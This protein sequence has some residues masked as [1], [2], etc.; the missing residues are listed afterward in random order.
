MF[1]RYAIV[2]E[3]QKRGALARKQ[4]YD[5]ATAEKKVITMAAR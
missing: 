1:R 5:A 2:N 3:D 4:A